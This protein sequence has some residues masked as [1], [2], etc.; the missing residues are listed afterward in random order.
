MGKVICTLYTLFFPSYLEL[1]A[2]AS[3][4]EGP[5]QEKSHK[6]P[7]TQVLSLE[8]NSDRGQGGK[9]TVAQGLPE[10]QPKGV[11]PHASLWS[12]DR[13]WTPLDILAELS[14][15]KDWKEVMEPL[16][17][18]ALPLR[19]P[20][21]ELPAYLRQSVRHR[22]RFGPEV[23]AYREGQ[24]K[25]IKA[26]AEADPSRSG[27]RWTALQRLANVIQ[28][29]DPHIFRDYAEKQGAVLAGLIPACPRWQPRDRPEPWD[30]AAYESHLGQLFAQHTV[31]QAVGAYRLPARKDRRKAWDL[32]ME[33]TAAGSWSGPWDPQEYFSSK[34]SFLS[35][36]YFVVKQEKWEPAELTS[37]GQQWTIKVKERG[38]LDPE[39]LSGPPACVPQGLGCEASPWPHEG[40][41]GRGK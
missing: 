30:K 12:L 18:T 4:Q 29:G 8:N 37:E 2:L 22:V 15:C 10:L 41:L 14:L 13:G 24:L 20:Q 31:D 5:T 21:A 9:R 40:S 11:L 32:I 6:G 1:N 23:V 26:I 28:L 16:V 7:K 3:K 34:G 39:G 17:G 25:K 33:E 35:W 27:V 38:C 36:L 19:R